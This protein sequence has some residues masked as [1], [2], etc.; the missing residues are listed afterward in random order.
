MTASAEELLASITACILWLCRNGPWAAWLQPS[1]QLRLCAVLH[2]LIQHQTS[3]FPY[4]CH[5]QANRNLQ[6]EKKKKAKNGEKNEK[7]GHKAGAQVG[8]VPG[9][10][11]T[12]CVQP[13]L[14][15]ANWA[16]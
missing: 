7:E 1:A 11:R 16:R 9:E 12:L 14:Q 6:E 3:E 8:L 5:E 13:C 2:I 10:L 4:G 15:N